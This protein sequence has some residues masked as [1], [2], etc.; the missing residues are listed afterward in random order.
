[1]NKASSPAVG[2]T[3]RFNRAFRDTFDD[4]AD[5]AR[6]RRQRFVL[7]A[8]GHASDGTEFVRMHDGR[9]RSHETTIGWV[10][11]VAANA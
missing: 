2:D 7:D 10:E 1:M 11:T 8:V 9:G 5:R 4:P 3:V 6:L